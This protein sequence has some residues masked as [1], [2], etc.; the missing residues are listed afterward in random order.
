MKE[1]KKSKSLAFLPQSVQ[2]FWLVL[3]EENQQADLGWP[4][5]LDLSERT[6]GAGA[7]QQSPRAGPSQRPPHS[8][9]G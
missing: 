4:W 6:V 3:T 7:L 8:S 2:W 1:V 9:G 5:A